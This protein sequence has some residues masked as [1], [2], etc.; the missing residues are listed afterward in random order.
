MKTIFLTL[1]LLMC[2]VALAHEDHGLGDGILHQLYHALF[3]I[4]FISVVFKAVSWLISKKDK[5]KK[6]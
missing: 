5:S 6:P 3:W 2:S 4:L 1:M